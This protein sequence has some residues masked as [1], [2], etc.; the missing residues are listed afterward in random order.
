MSKCKFEHGLARRLF[1]N[2]IIISVSFLLHVSSSSLLPSARHH[3]KSKQILFRQASHVPNSESCS[4]RTN[5]IGTHRNTHPTHYGITLQPGRQA[6]SCFAS[7]LAYLALPNSVAYH[8]RLCL[9]SSPLL[10]Y[11]HSACW[12]LVYLSLRITADDGLVIALSSRWTVHGHPLELF[13]PR[14]H[15]FRTSKAYIHPI[16]APYRVSQVF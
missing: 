9:R 14:L 1:W 5:S 7:I 12:L 8:H 3:P 2:R 11:L 13:E 6:T 16:F 10:H 4:S 15:P